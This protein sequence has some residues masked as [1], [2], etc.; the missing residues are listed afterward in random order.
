MQRIFISLATYKKLNTNLFTRNID[1]CYQ[2]WFSKF[3]CNNLDKT[4]CGWK[5]A[6]RSKLTTT[7]P[8]SQA[9][10]KP[11]LK[12]PCQ[13]FCLGYIWLFKFSVC[14]R[15]VCR[16]VGQKSMEEFD[17]CSQHGHGTNI[18]SHWALGMH[19]VTSWIRFLKIFFKHWTIDRM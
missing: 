16:Q 13:Q 19:K 10:W 17:I 12:T 1:L 14:L 18:K 15:Q 9:F 6:F 3:H 5:S 11:D 8:I 7:L 4:N 2:E